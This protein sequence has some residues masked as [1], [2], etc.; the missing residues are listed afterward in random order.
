MD[1]LGFH[2]EVTKDEWILER[3]TG[4]EIGK[5]IRR[6][7]FVDGRDGRSI[8]RELFEIPIVPAKLF[9]SGGSSR[10]ITNSIEAKVVRF[11]RHGHSQQMTDSMLAHIKS[12]KPFSIQSF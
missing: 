6:N 1:Y 5:V 12:P 4:I 11:H 9:V 8:P 3:V 10:Q 7:V 2:S